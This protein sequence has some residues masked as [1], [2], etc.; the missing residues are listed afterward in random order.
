[1]I[2]NA[3]L[4]LSAIEKVKEKGGSRKEEGDRATEGRI[5]VAFRTYTVI[6]VEKRHR[7][8]CPPSFGVW[9][10][11]T[12]PMYVMRYRLQLVTRPT[13]RHL[14]KLRAELAVVSDARGTSPSSFRSRALSLSLSLSLSHS[15]ARS[16]F[17][18]VCHL[19]HAYT[20]LSVIRW[21]NRSCS[22]HSLNFV[23]KL[24]PMICSRSLCMYIY[25]YIYI[26]IF[27]R[28]LL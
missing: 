17:L 8:G 10:I 4:Q 12:W 9:K 13:G 26:Y 6:R 5:G 22:Y 24:N 18:P 2:F 11:A 28:L 21:S 1:V 27:I 25:I 20:I 16:R 23:Y 19:A 3:P 7:E 15:L 14:G